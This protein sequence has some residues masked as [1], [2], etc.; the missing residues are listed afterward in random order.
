MMYRHFVIVG[1]FIVEKSLDEI[2]SL[3]NQAIFHQAVDTSYGCDIFYYK[4][5]VV[6][7]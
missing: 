7:F 4:N 6:T 1:P 5:P 3:G 2:R